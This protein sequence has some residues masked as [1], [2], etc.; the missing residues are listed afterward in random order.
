MAEL[1][2]QVGAAKA[3]LTLARVDGVDDPE[4]ALEWALSKG[5]LDRHP[6]FRDQVCLTPQGEQ[7]V[8]AFWRAYEYEQRARRAR[9][10]LIVSDGTAPEGGASDG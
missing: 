6:L 9:R 1:L 2:T 8:W 10:H 7:I 5:L 3:I 4:R